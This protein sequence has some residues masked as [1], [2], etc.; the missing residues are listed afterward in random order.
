MTTWTLEGIYAHFRPDILLPP[1]VPLPL[2]VLIAQQ[3]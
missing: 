3:R 2:T 1:E